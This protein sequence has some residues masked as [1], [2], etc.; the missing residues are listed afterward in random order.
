MKQEPIQINILPSESYAIACLYMREIKCL[1]EMCEE[2]LYYYGETEYYYVLL[3][4][5]AFYKEQLEN[6]KPIVRETNLC[7]DL[8]KADWKYDENLFM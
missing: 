5:L 2:E 6:I 4:N 3:Y 1:E 8:E 7:N